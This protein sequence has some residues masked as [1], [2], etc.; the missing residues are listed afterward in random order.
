MNKPLLS[1]QRPV[2]CPCGGAAPDARGDTATKAPR[3]VQ[4]CGRYIDGG[5]AAPRALE[6][7]RSRYSAYVLGATDYLRATWDPRTCPADLDVDPTVPDAP[8]WLGLQIKGFA[9]S[10]ADHATV[11]FIARYKVGGRAY[12]LHESSRFVRGDDGR[13]RYV[14]GDVN[15]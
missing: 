6:L 1:L 12:R 10:D 15:E 4:C 7:M 5:E 13:W 14:D 2:D 3:F 8:R 9:E 11:E